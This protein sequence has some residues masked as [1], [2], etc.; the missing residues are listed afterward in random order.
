M[1]PNKPV[2]ATTGPGGQPPVDELLTDIRP[3]IERATYG[4]QIVATLSRQLV[5]EYGRGFAEKN[6]RRMVLFGENTA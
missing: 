2:T 5:L 4:A 6:L 1:K 3:A